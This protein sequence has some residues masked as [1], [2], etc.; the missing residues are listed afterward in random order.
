MLKFRPTAALVLIPAAAVCVGA[1]SGTAA[2][3]RPTPAER[4]GSAPPAARPA[5]ET[6]PAILRLAAT[7]HYGQPGNAS[8]FSVIIATGARQAWTFGG[9][10]PGG[11]ST[12]IAARWDGSS[13][14]PSALPSGLTGFINDASAPAANDVWAAGQYGRYVLHWDG[15]VWHIARR[16]PSGQITGLTAISAGDVWVFGTSITGSRLVG[17]WHFDGRSW[18]PVRGQAGS[19]YRASAVSHTDIWAIA[20]TSNA[21]IL[22]RY[23]GRAWSRVRTGPVFNGAQPQDILAVSNRDVW[24]A[25]NEVSRDGTPRLVLAHWN[26]SRWSRLASGLS[27]WVGQLAPGPHC[28]VLLTATP[29]N[30]VATGLILHASPHGWG[31]TIVVADGLGSGVS[32]VALV[33]RTSLLWATGGI[34]T[35]LGGEAAIWSGPMA[36]ADHHADDN[37]P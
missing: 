28:D 24:M 5:A 27:A 3:A 25:G 30:A 32:D 8:G 12:P 36:R 37:L 26:G 7:K 16:W 17:T 15:K 21:D 9:T 2:A 34:L 29:A 23:D 4:A 18:A 1:L 19:I 33:P 31:T 35:R 10:N 22:L 13:L 14:T 6:S 11:P 20:A